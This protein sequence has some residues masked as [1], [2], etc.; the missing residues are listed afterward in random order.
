MKIKLKE[1]QICQEDDW[2]NLDYLRD[3]KYWYDR[4]FL[5]EDAVGFKIC[6][7][8]GFLT[9]DYETEQELCRRYN[10]CRKII[11]MNVIVTGN[12]KI[13]YHK[14]FLEGVLKENTA[15]LD[16]GCGAGLFLNYIKN[17][18]GNTDLYGVE[19]N[20]ASISYG[21]EEFKLQIDTEIQENK[22]D[23]ICC[24]HVLEHIQYPYKLL[25][26]FRELLVDDGILYISVPEI[27]QY[28]ILDE[29]SGA[30]AVEFEEL[31]HLNHVN[32]FSRVSLRNLMARSGF[33]I[34]KEDGKL[35]GYTIL[36]RKGSE[37]VLTKENFLSIIE[38]VERQKR[39][40]ELFKQEKYEEARK[41]HAG[42]ADAWRLNAM[43]NFKDLEKQEGILKE[44]LEATNSYYKIKKQ[45]AF[46][47]TQWDNNKARENGI[48]NHVRDSKRLWEEL[49]EEKAG[50]DEYY[51][52]LAL[53]EIKYYKNFE[54]AR[55]LL[56]KILEINP[57]RWSEIQN[58]IG[59]C[60]K[61]KGQL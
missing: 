38:L 40:M 34:V 7:K 5:Y 13:E 30:N 36:C 4:D 48:T 12:R 51:Y 39:A 44:G 18:Y 29:A 20:E 23:F 43:K 53:L 26:K 28:D 19:T 25:Q 15:I 60:W 21:R 52:Y 3:H 45:L 10:D 9:Y 49:I 2:K 57:A 58:L 59:L 11:D 54:K 46:L 17:N 56:D 6:K 32:Q 37:N 24:Y 14:K 31:Y 35:Y 1:C 42:Y 8:C 27:V 50:M 16:Y 41:A 47:Y 33:E 55:G 61:E 22:Y